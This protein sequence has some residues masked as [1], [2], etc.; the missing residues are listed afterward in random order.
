MMNNSKI[1]HFKGI[2]QNEG[3]LMNP[4]IKVDDQGIITA[5]TTTIPEE[6]K[7]L[8]QSV[9]GYALPGW[10]NAHSHAFQYAMA[11]IAENSNHSLS[12]QD[13]FWSWREAM[14]ELA[15]SIDPDDMQAIATMLYK[16]MLCYGYTHVAEF[17]YLHHH[18]S[19]QPYDN[20]SEMA[21]RLICAAKTAGIGITLI[22]IFYQKG[23]FNQPATT[24]QRRFISTD[25]NAY[26]E[27]LETTQNS[28][29]FYEYAN[30]A[31]GIHSMR[32]VDTQ[33][34]KQVALDKPKQI[35]L[36]IHIS[37]QLQEIDDCLA[38]LD[39]RPV[40]WL[41]EHLAV[42]DSYH[43]VHATHLIDKEIQMIAKKQ[44]NVVLC[45][46][47]EGN[48]G[49]GV[50]AL[51]SFMNQKGSFSIGTDSHIGLNPLEELRWLDYTQRLLSH[52]RD[53]FYHSTLA[54]SA[55][56][57]LQ[58][59]TIAGRKAMGNTE[60]R[61]FKEGWFLDALIIDAN[62]PIIQ[63]TSD[64]HLTST[65][66]YCADSTMFQGTICNGQWVI[67]NGKHDHEESINEQFI[68][69]LNILSHR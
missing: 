17:H 28:T 41:C 53:T 69:H 7:P 9:D 63:S 24:R 64:Q 60:E 34:I 45:P 21:E 3:W 40:E 58:S 62:V 49:D 18:Q 6:D 30:V 16:E 5:I 50:F 48:L 27:L 12:V 65:M 29:K 54:D 32:A 4:F 61:F 66:I 38:H 23:G 68:K 36:H 11:G 13:S 35:P 37:E 44:A 20:L 31:Y 2:L 15:L 14:Y 55:L 46:S 26:Y 39:K 51:K 42:D 56:M 19:G 57:A 47:T 22:P 1:Y 33:M 8:V 43:L 52:K 25:L 10:Q 67:K 59:V